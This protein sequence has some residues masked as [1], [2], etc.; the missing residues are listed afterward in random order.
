MAG[1]VVAHCDPVAVDVHILGPAAQMNIHSRGWT[2]WGAAAH[3]LQTGASLCHMAA[4]VS[5]IT[6]DCCSGRCRQAAVATAAS[7][8]R[9]LC[10]LQ[11]LALWNCWPISGLDWRLAPWH[12]HKLLLQ[13]LLLARQNGCDLCQTKQRLCAVCCGCAD[14]GFLACS[15]SSSGSCLGRMPGSLHDVISSV[16]PQNTGRI[17][18]QQN[19]ATQQCKATKSMSVYVQ[20]GLKVDWRANGELDEC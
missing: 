2:L 5:M 16:L 7:C 1:V 17:Q 14:L 20:P 9:R 8:G 15:H 18:L 6:A 12:P 11:A 4:D 3:H 19:Q 10:T 13:L